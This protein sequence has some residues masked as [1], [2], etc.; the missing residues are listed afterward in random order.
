[1]VSKPAHADPAPWPDADVADDG[2]VAYPSSDGEPMAE[3]ESQLV[4][5][6]ATFHALRDWYRHRP[7]VYVGSDLLVYYRR[8]DNGVRVAPDVFV[9]FGATGNHPRDSWRVWAEGKAPDFVLE[10]AS[11]GTWQQD[12]GAKREIYAG[13][14]V[15]EYWRFDPTGEC[16]T[17]GLAGERLVNGVYEPMPVLAE[18]A[19]MLRGYSPTL[20]LD[21]CVLEGTAFRDADSYVQEELALRLYDPVSEEWLRMPWEEAAARRVAEAAQREAEAAQRTAESAQQ[22]AEAENRRLREE[23]RRLQSGQ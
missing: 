6:I 21:I 1:M 17:P 12:V 15:T 22:E 14:G 7:E 11:E 13:L 10:I 4:P 8:G 23:L 5:M 20:G 9:V 19:G 18:D 3:S 2:G 16:F